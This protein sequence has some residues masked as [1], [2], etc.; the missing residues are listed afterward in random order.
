MKLELYKLHGARNKFVFV[1]LF[2]SPCARSL[3]KAERVAGGCECFLVNQCQR[4]YQLS[5]ARRRLEKMAIML[6]KYLNAYL[7]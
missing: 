1:N 2:A 7:N 3:S 4:N 5:M 6:F